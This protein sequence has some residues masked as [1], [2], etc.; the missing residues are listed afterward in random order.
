M[1]L[2]RFSLFDN[3]T[4]KL[5]VTGD[6]GTVGP[7]LKKWNAMMLPETHPEFQQVT[8][9]TGG[10]ICRGELIR[11]RNL[12]GICNDIYNPAMGSTNQIFARNVKFE[13]T[14]PH[15]GLTELVRN[16]HADRLS[17]LKPDPQVI[18]RKLF[19]REQ[20]NPDACNFGKCVEGGGLS[21]QCDYKKAPFFAV[22][23]SHLAVSQEVISW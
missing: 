16:R 17:L 5:Y 6:H 20:T 18:S 1:E 15:L 22:H 19:T 14:F 2:I 23:L 8:T 4:Y 11:H 7:L 9:S 12:T 13:A 10:Q 3:N 21:T